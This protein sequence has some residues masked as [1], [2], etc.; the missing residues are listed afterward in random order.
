MLNLRGRLHPRTVLTGATG[1]LYVRFFLLDVLERPLATDRV[2][3]ANDNQWRIVTVIVV[4]VF[5]GTVGY[6]M[7]AC[8]SGQLLSVDKIA[9]KSP[10][11]RGR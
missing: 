4:K 3:V 5:E 1:A 2:F 7:S 8:Y 6:S 11:R 9:Y 10:G